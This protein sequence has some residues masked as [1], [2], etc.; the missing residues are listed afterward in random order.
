MAANGPRVMAYAYS[1]GPVGGQ[2]LS[3]AALVAMSTLAVTEQ[4][5]PGTTT[6]AR[7]LAPELFETQLATWAASLSAA[8]TQGAPSGTYAISYDAA[9]QRVTIE[10]TNAVAFIPA[11][12]GNLATW[13]GFTQTLAGW[14]TSWTGESAPAAIAELIGVT[15]EPA[16]EAA[17]VDLTSYRHGRSIAVAWSNHNTH[18]VKFTFSRSTTLAQIKAGYLTTGRVRLWQCG[19]ATAYSASN[20]DG[21][22]D[23]FVIAADEP[24]E[25]GDIG[26]LWTLD[27]VVG[28]S[29]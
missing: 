23:G 27:L 7:P 21:Y 16:E 26:E 15:V 10:T 4:G 28:V 19:D 8:P 1:E 6:Y 17:R 3:T 12:L 11:M 25:D 14:A 2:G 13:L 5:T 18:R 24:T 9:T 29:Q 20:P 22:V